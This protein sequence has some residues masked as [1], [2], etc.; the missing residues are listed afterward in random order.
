MISP[1]IFFNLV[2]GIIGSLR[3]FT[4]GYVMTGGG[5]L[6]STLFY[7]LYLYNQAFKHLQMG[8][9]SAL[10]WILFIIIMFFTWLIF[11]SSSI[12]VYYEVERKK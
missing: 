3:T 5:P 8:Y 4:Q 11:R 2:T 12:W 9:A 7:A 6:E 1:T 10:A